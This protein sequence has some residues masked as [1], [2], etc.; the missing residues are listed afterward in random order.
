[1]D[2]MPILKCKDAELN[3]YFHLDLHEKN[4]ICTFF[5]L[6]KPS[7]TEKQHTSSLQ[8]FVDG[9]VEGISSCFLGTLPLFLSKNSIYLDAFYFDP[10]TTLENNQHILSYAF[11]CLKNRNIDINMVVGYERWGT[12]F[13]YSL[14]YREALKEIREKSEGAFCIRLGV[15]AIDE[16]M[17]SEPDYF[18]ERLNAIIES[19]V[20]LPEKCILLL[21]FGSLSNKNI[22]EIINQAKDSIKMIRDYN[23]SK[24]YFCG[25]SMP[26]HIGEA[27]TTNTTAVIQRKEML[28]WKAITEDSRFID[29]GFSDYGIRSSKS[30][31]NGYGKNINGKIWYTIENAYF[32]TRGHKL[33]DPPHGGQFKGLAYSVIKSGYHSIYSKNWADQEITKATVKAIINIKKWICIGTNRHMHCVLLEIATHKQKISLKPRANKR[34][35]IY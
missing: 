23:F 20:L 2:Y 7:N 17:V 25:C 27:V 9:K 5:D 4:A 19:L 12:E 26:D 10:S 33:S 8:S 31:D 11:D 13:D 14:E 1:M 16:D 15:E 29:V 34:I 30:Q 22:H 21:D 28:A 18:H 24:I 6:T 3:A 32:V 35:S